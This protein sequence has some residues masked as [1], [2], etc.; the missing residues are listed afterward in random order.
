M[1]QFT[2]FLLVL[3]SLVLMFLVIWAFYLGVTFVINQFEF[4]D[5]RE[6]AIVTVSSLVVLMSSLIIATAIR[7]SIQKG[8]KKIHPMKAELYSRYVST[9]DLLKNSSENFDSELIRMNRQMILWAGDD[10]LNEYG[11]L[12]SMLEKGDDKI[13]RQATNVLLEIRKDLGHNNRGVNI[14]LISDSTISESQSG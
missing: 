8:D 10:V 12:L 1:K 2:N 9:Y 6:T 13:Y 7:S 3:A 11:R 4:F 5:A 14:E